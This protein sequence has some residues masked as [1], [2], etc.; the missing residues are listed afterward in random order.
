MLLSFQHF[1]NQYN[2][3]CKCCINIQRQYCSMGIYSIND[4]T[5]LPSTT[6]LTTQLTTDTI[7][8][9]QEPFLET[10]DCNND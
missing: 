7:I 3:L 1:S 2:C 8:T 6:Q 5:Q 9:S 4:S 10:N